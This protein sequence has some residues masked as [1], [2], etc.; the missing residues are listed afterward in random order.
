MASGQDIIIFQFSRSKVERGDFRSFLDLYGPDKLPT[1]GRLRR[2]KGCFLFAVEGYDHDRREIYAIPEVRAFY[3]AFWKEWPYWLY[4]CCLVENDALK[5]MTLCCLDDLAVTQVDGHPLSSATMNL[6]ALKEFLREGFC[7]MDELAKRAE[8]FP[9]LVEER[10]TEVL[11]F[12]GLEDEWP[13][14]RIPG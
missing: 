5:P 12:F 7:H 2:M 11:R 6:A 13:V 4:F 9:E 10:K 14:G 8:M 1:G 3:Q